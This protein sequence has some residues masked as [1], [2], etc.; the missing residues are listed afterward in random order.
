MPKRALMIEKSQLRRGSRRLTTRHKVFISFHH[1]DLECKEEF[2]KLMK[3]RMIDMSVDTGG[4]D[5]TGKKTDDVRRI[6]RD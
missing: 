2:V 3:G 1:A 5:D 4:I 6:I